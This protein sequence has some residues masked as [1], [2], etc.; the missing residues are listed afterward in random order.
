MVTE[1]A[2]PKEMEMSVE[3]AARLVGM[4]AAMSAVLANR[5]ADL[6]ADLDRARKKHEPAILKCTTEMKGIE[7]DLKRWAK[8]NKRRL[9]A[10]SRSMNFPRGEVGFRLGKWRVKTGRGVTLDACA[11]RLKGF[12]WGAKYLRAREPD[13]NREA[14]IEDRERLTAEQL[15]AAGVAIVQ[16]EK[17]FVEPKVDE[18]NIEA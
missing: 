1:K 9:F 3:D 5:Q 8:A 17:F 14:L 11:K 13:V 4:Y 16:D 10:A 6:D 12:R 7:N 18:K 15:E 2:K